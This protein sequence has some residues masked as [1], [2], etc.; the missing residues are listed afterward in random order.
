MVAIYC[1]AK[2]HIHIAQMPSKKYCFQSNTGFEMKFEEFQNGYQIRYQN[3]VI[4]PNLR[5]HV[6]HSLP[7]RFGSINCTFW[8]EMLFKE[9]QDGCHAAWCLNLNLSLMS[10][11]EPSFI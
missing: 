1:F 6:A 7:P 5:H 9:F 11:T 3:R 4:M 10:P 2:L 8:E